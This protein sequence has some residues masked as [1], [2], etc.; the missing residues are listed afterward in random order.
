MTTASIKPG[1]NEPCPCGSGKKYKRCCGEG[2]LSVSNPQGASAPRSGP[3]APLAGPEMIELVSLSQAGRYAELERRARELTQRNARA[4]FA[5]KSLALALKMLG[6]ESLSAV[7]KAAEL[8]PMDAEAQSNLGVALWEAGRIAEAGACFQRVIRIKPE[9][10]G[11]HYRLGSVLVNLGR[12]GDAATCY[13]RALAL[14]PNLL[15]AHVR[16]AHLLMNAAD[17]AG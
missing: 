4:G 7:Q 16:L 6:K 8:M 12:L 1:R 10:F 5:W 13:Q 15:D 9:D 2:E 14:N 3:T 17:W 11:A